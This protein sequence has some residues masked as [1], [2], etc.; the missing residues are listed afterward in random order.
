MSSF[1][2]P[3]VSDLLV[4]IAMHP[5]LNPKPI[6]HVHRFRTEFG[7][8]VLVV[9]GSQV[10]A[11]P[12]EVGSMLDSTPPELIESLLDRF[13]ITSTPFID[14]EPLRSPA[15]HALSLAVA[16]KC[17]LACSYCYAQEGAFGGKE[18][19]MDTQ[20][21]FAAV[22]LLFSG[23]KCG[24]RV[25]LTFL[26][27]EPLTHRNLIYQ[28][29]ER[30]LVNAKRQGVEV[31]FSITT[32]G[33]LITP[34]VGEFFEEH[35]FAVTV[36]LDGV[37]AVN[38]RL[39]M[40]KDGRGSYQRTLERVQPLL[41]R[42]CK[43]QVSARVTVTPD[44][45]N[46]LETLNAFL[47]KG[48]HSV[49]F[50]PMLRSPRGNGE[51]SH[52]ALESMLTSMIE[53]GEEFERRVHAGQRFGFAN[54]NTALHEI[55]KGTHR[56]YPCGAGAGYMGVSAEGDLYACH[57]FV[58]DPVGLMGDVIHGVNV[59]RQNQWLAARN[60]HQQEPCRS[61]WARYLCGGGCHH[62][63]IQRG[64]PACDYI[65]GWLD[66]CLKA[67]VRMLEAKPEFFAK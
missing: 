8:F 48:F 32:N 7:E 52:I 23:A 15:L 11:L 22:D 38:D 14:T 60:V 41:R 30:A 13:G 63:V 65:R 35:G 66:Y 25:Q 20:V 40:F 29:T 64:R 19:A 53:C 61:C 37:G 31:G 2:S 39:R 26:G 16:Q 28:C 59:E 44:N 36:S 10:Y 47:D 3:D 45:L 33:T 62:E 50:S 56:P 57:R 49:G 58:E 21:A 51:M 1:S 27:G 55:H 43:M 54:L 5:T 6:S 24:E 34:E 12:D 9:N 67:Y 46:L 18:T 42:Q 4:Q 17:N